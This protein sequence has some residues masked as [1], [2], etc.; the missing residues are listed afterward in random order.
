MFKHHADRALA[1]FRTVSFGLFHVSILLRFG[2][3]SN[4]GA[5]QISFA[6]FYRS[7]LSRIGDFGV[8]GVALFKTERVITAGIIRIGKNILEIM[9]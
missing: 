2:A 8:T 3:S 4:P 9:R 5:V 7:S 6:L 1:D